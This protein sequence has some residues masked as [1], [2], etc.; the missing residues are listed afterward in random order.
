MFLCG[1]SPTHVAFPPN[2]NHFRK[3]KK[4]Q[5]NVHQKSNQTTNFNFEKKNC[6][7]PCLQDPPSSS[8]KRNHVRRSWHQGVAELGMGGPPKI[9]GF[10]FYPP[11]WMV[12]IMVENPMKHG[13]IWGYPYFILFLETPISV[14]LKQ[15]L[16]K[17]HNQLPSIFFRTCPAAIRPP[18]PL[19]VVA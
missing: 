5:E 7:P 6:C 12:K 14:S 19:H 4:L 18:I 17:I 9:G 8:R 1:K 11:K 13:M 10:R 15:F 2:K 16:N 3:Q